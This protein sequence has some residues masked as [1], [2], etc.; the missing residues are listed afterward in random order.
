[1]WQSPFQKN[2]AAG[3]WYEPGMRLKGAV[4]WLV[5]YCVLDCSVFLLPFIESQ[6]H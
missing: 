4:G 3:V 2:S 1:M 6:N 5:P